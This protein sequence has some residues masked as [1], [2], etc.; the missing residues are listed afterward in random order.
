MLDEDVAVLVSDF[1]SRQDHQLVRTASARAIP[2]A[3]VAVSS[4]ST[5]CCRSCSDMKLVNLAGGCRDYCTIAR[6]RIFDVS[7]AANAVE[8]PQP[9][10]DLLVGN[11]LR[12]Q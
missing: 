7:T 10:R 2:S 11:A 5:V 6:R 3:G 9:I 8:T 4:S 12:L 1:P